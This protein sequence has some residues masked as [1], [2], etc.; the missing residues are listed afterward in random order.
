MTPEDNNTAYRNSAEHIDD[1]LARL[2][3]MIELCLFRTRRGRTREPLDQLRG[4]VLSDREIAELLSADRSEP[5]SGHGGEEG[6]QE[7]V[8]ALRSVEA[9]I[10]QRRAASL[11]NGIH[12]ALPYLARI[13]QLDRFEEQCLLLCLAP[14]VNRK[15]GKLFAYLHD[16]ATRKWPSMDLLLDLLCRSREEKLRARRVF[17][18]QSPLRQVRTGTNGGPV[19]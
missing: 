2:D 6:P 3:L 13:F 10:E 1:E 18:P 14:E 11:E 19:A 8:S 5:A 15:Y 9:R 16:D 7:L 17:G 4:L 12:L